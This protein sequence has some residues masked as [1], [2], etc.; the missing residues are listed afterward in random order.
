MWGAVALPEG[1]WVS[2]NDTRAVRLLA[3]SGAAPGVGVPGLSDGW[4]WS[5]AE[6][7]LQ[8]GGRCSIT[9]GRLASVQHSNPRLF[10]NGGVG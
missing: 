10:Q 3:G 1:S 8:P 5:P 2:A 4:G 7:S 9:P 6:L